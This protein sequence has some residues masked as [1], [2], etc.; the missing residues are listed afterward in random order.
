[1]LIERSPEFSNDYRLL[2]SELFNTVYDSDFDDEIKRAFMIE[3]SAGLY[4]HE[5]VMDKEV[6]AYATLLKLY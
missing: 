4:K 2:M 3:L 1:M 5:S 6:N